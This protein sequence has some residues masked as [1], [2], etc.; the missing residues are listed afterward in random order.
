[1]SYTYRGKGTP[2]K[3]ASGTSQTCSDC[4]ASRT[5]YQ[6]TLCPFHQAAP[7][8]LAAVKAATHLFPFKPGWYEGLREMLDDAIAHAE[9]RR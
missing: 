9:G 2:P 7:E 6:V 5:D 8:L 1:M 4:T 3:T